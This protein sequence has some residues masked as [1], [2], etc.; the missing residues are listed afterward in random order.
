[1]SSTKD[2][3]VRALSNAKD[4]IEEGWIQHAAEDLAGNVCAAQALGLNIVSAVGMEPGLSNNEKCLA[5]QQVGSA[6]SKMFVRAIQELFSEW[7]EV[8]PAMLEIARWNDQ[9][10]RTQ[11]EVVHTFDHA[12]KLAERDL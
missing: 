2:M 4:R 11:Q 3:V 8:D 10:G 1:M 12:I 5:R 7:A 9:E 6:A